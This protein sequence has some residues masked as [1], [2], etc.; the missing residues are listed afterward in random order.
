MADDFA[1]NGFDTFIPDYLNGD[2]VPQDDPT[3][4]FAS[5]YIQNSAQL[6]YSL[7]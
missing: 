3:V 2:P 7:T 4:C 6:I 5:G 1:A